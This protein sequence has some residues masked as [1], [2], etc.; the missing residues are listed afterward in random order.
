MRKKYGNKPE[1]FVRH[2]HFAFAR[3]NIGEGGVGVGVSAARNYA[4]VCNVALHFMG[5][6]FQ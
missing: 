6:C 2:G 5:L 1:P 4:A 3:T